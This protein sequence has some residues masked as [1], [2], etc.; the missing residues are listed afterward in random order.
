VDYPS[1]NLCRRERPYKHLHLEN[2]DSDVP[3][4]E[5]RNVIKKTTAEWFSS[6]SD[7][8]HTGPV[9]FRGDETQYEPGDYSDPIQR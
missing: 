9:K 6:T 3:S 2:N 5:M 7:H 4:E 1:I 8:W